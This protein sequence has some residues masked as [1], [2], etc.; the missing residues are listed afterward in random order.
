MCIFK[1]SKLVN[2]C[3]AILTLKI[4]E[5]MQ[6]FQHV[7]L[8]YFEKGKNATE[9][10]KKI[11]AVYGKGAGT[12]RMCQKWLVTFSAGDYLLDSATRPG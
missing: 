5:N 11:C 1:K 12:D 6:H 2:S 7:I 3:V 9:T 4:E 8:Y 10:H